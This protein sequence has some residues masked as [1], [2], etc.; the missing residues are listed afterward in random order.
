MDP[1]LTVALK[2]TLNAVERLLN[3]FR[4][5]RMVHLLIGVVAFGMLVYAIALL[6]KAG[7]M[8]T[9]LL[10][11]LFGS[12]GLITVSSARITYF[13]NRAFKLVED[14]IR[15][16]LESGVTDEQHKSSFSK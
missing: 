13:F 1:N 10:I 5:E 12:S 7:E 6:F 16:L 15:K 9:Q 8:S 14:V 4:I 11:C 3:L 2:E